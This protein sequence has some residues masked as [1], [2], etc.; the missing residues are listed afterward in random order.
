MTPS[1]YGRITLGVAAVGAASIMIA[2][3]LLR[4]GFGGGAADA[5]GS[6]SQAVDA[7][8]PAPAFPSSDVLTNGAPV[9]TLDQPA[10][11]STSG[12]DEGDSHESGESHDSHD[13]HDS[14][15]SGEK[16]HD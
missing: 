5:A 12:G 8:V 14:H 11:F 2:A 9:T 3:A 15:E 7:S 4:P 10:T 16:S 13:S 6:N 1:R